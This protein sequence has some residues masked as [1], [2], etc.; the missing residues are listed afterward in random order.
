MQI[1][2]SDTFSSLVFLSLFLGNL[3]TAKSFTS[4]DIVLSLFSILLIALLYSWRRMLDT[5]EDFMNKS[6]DTY[7]S[8]PEETIEFAGERIKLEKDIDES[9]DRNLRVK[10][11]SQKVNRYIAIIIYFAVTIYFQ[12]KMGDKTTLHYTTLNMACLF[13]LQSSMLGHLVLALF[14]QVIGVIY[15]QQFPGVFYIYIPT[16]LLTFVALNLQEKSYI[17]NNIL[18]L[19]ANINNSMGLKG[20]F[21][22]A[23]ITFASILFLINIIIPEYQKKKPTKSNKDDLVLRALKKLNRLPKSSSTSPLAQAA[24]KKALKN[25]KLSLENL[26]MLNQQLESMEDQLS[27][28]EELF[29]N[30]PD[31]DLPMKELSSSK[32]QISNA[33]EMI[34]EIEKRETPPT[35]QELEEIGELFKNIKDLQS[36]AQGKFREA[37]S[38]NSN[39]SPEMNLAMNSAQGYFKET[40]EMMGNLEKNLELQKAIQ[41]ESIEKAKNQEGQ[42]TQESQE[43]GEAQTPEVQAENPPFFSE[44]KLEKLY[45]IFK[46][47][48]IICIALIGFI[49]LKKFLS[50]K[51]NKI[52]KSKSRSIKRLLKQYKRIVKKKLSPREEIIE[53]YNLFR[54]I[55]KEIFFDL[56]EESPPP[57]VMRELLEEK[58]PRLKNELYIV[59]EEFIQCFYGEN[60][61]LPKNL[62]EFRQSLKK[63]LR[64]YKRISV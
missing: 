7:L 29:K 5:H 48:L 47:I 6:V 16:L 34:N 33:R 17:L 51:K 45:N 21:L 31:L 55:S 9:E 59:H 40:E 60:E 10:S 1:K 41:K 61:V 58:L 32:Q 38:S 63:S 3:S 37:S 49:L 25:K 4:S 14:I 2:S 54:N 13:V 8:L 42:G 62:K 64:I 36:K 15:L 20:N 12:V 23:F 18:K 39:Q 43:M 26:K 35:A 30:I 57:Q 28:L 27:T 44:E 46:K 22:K 56:D 53:S 52:L 19:K 24:A 11:I 50:S